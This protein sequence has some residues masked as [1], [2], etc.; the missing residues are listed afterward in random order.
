MR[1]AVINQRQAIIKK[2]KTI[3][4]VNRHTY[5]TVKNKNRASNFYIS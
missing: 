5:N 3:N 4:R 2:T 1:P